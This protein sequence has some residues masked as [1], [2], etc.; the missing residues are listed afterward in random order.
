MN[1]VFYEDKATKKARRDEDFQKKKISRSS[2]VDE[3][4]KEL[5]DEPEELHLGT[6]NKKSKFARE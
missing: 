1:P 6:M 2:Y 3:L 4:R 5:Y